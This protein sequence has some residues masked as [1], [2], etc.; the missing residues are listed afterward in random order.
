MDAEHQSDLTVHIY[1]TLSVLVDWGR[2]SGS[3]EADLD[4]AISRALSERFHQT[5]LV[6]NGFSSV[7]SPTFHTDYLR[8]SQAVQHCFYSVVYIDPASFCSVLADVRIFLHTILSVN[9]VL[10]RKVLLI[11][12]ETL[13]GEV[14]EHYK[15]QVGELENA[16]PDALARGILWNG[17]GPFQ[18][19]SDALGGWIAKV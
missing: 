11:A 17:T 6:C 4:G 16:M 8:F 2:F 9:R 5:W 3:Q 19:F 7:R 15:R 14:A 12:D 10:K 18:E 1:S 13:V